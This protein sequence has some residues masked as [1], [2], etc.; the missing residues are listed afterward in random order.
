[1]DT[2]T[3]GLPLSEDTVAPAPETPLPEAPETDGEPT[4]ETPEGDAP[5]TEVASE[6][7]ENS[8]EELAK[9]DPVLRKWLDKKLSWERDKA[10]ESNRRL[11]EA[12]TEKVKKLAEES[13]LSAQFSAAVEQA[14]ATYGGRAAEQFTG[15]V[16]YIAENG[17]PDNWD[18]KT[19]FDEMTNQ[20][21]DA[22]RTSVALDT[23]DKRT[24]L[25][26]QEF[27][28]W[29]ASPALV[30]EWTKALQSRDPQ[31]LDMAYLKAAREAAESSLKLQLSKEAE[32]EQAKE[33]ER[34]AK[35]EALKATEETRMAGDR[36]TRDL[37]VS[38]GHR[39]TTPEDLEKMP[40]QQIARLAREKPDELN[41][42]IKEA[43]EV[44]NRRSR[45][46]TVR[47]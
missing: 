24:K 13:A 35:A 25:L 47:T 5:E 9:N 8:L 21:F 30:D 40:K 34:K 14:R 20:L 17:I 29:A 6:F 41:R 3:A 1:M 46:E 16:K 42:M 11:R 39:L 2:D 18:A 4:P 37:P 32:A 26:A 28:E 7:D 15:L 23:A 43:E 10:N 44:A 12:E 27:P 19:Y 45:R 33:T 22:T 38:N 36:P 31:K